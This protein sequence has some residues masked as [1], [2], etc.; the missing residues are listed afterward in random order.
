MFRRSSL[1]LLVLAGCGGAEP[2]DTTATPPA[3]DV[4]CPSEASPQRCS[5]LASAA[6]G[7]GHGELAWAYTVLECESPSA[8]QCVAMWQ[9]YSK[10]APTQTDAL[11]VLHAACDHLPAACAQL[12]AWHTERGHAL[13][14]AAYQKRAEATRQAPAAGSG[15]PSEQERAANA[16]ALATDLAAVMHVTD[17]PP[18]TDAI[19]QLVGHELRAPAAQPTAAKPHIERK[20]WKMHAAELGST[21][22]ACTTKTT[23][24]KHPVAPH[25]CVSEVRPFEDDQIALRNRCAEAVSVAYAGARADHSTAADQLR[26]RP[27]E[28]RSIGISHRDVGPL[29][30]AVCPDTCSI[31]GSPDSASAA[32]TGQDSSY[33]CTR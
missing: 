9:R 23:V 27:Y 10:L 28:A 16:L 22:D 15:A 19:A 30:Y 13:A 26:L 32:W 17:A 33:Y 1:V 29:T 3:E 8:A 25:E 31:S 6:E 2:H 4:G 21:S 11:D 7:A 14:A 24:D 20:A 12:A 18:R 5:D